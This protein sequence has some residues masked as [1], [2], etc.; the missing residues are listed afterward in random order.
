[1]RSPRFDQLSERSAAPSTPRAG[2]GLPALPSGSVQAEYVPAP[3][4]AMNARVPLS[5]EIARAERHEKRRVVCG[6]GAMRSRG[7]KSEIGRTTSGILARDRRVLREE[8][9][10]V[11]GI[12]DGLV[13]VA[14]VHQDMDL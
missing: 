7:S 1:M 11:G 9:R 6:I 3:R 12:G 13:A 14:V 5:G 10:H 8:L 4:S 2:D